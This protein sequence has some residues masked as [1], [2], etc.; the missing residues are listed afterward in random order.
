LREL[1]SIS[2]ALETLLPRMIPAA[3]EEID[4]CEARGRVAFED[5]RAHM[6]IPPFARSPYDGYAFAA[7]DVEGA[8]KYSPVTLRVVREI[9]AGSPA[10]EG[11]GPGE[12]VKLMT[13]APV[14]T[15][16]DTVV[17][18]ETTEFT[19]EAVS[20]FEP[21]SPG[22]DVIPAGED[23]LA[24]DVII[25]KGELI[26]AAVSGML[27]AQGLSRVKV[28]VRPVA[29]ILSTGSELAGRTELIGDGKIHD[30]NRYSLGAA[31]AGLGLSVRFIG[32]RAD[33]PEGIAEAVKKGLEDCD[34][35]LTTGGVSVGDYDYTAS[36]SEAAGVG[37]L[38][39]NVN[40]KPGGTCAIGMKGEKPVFCLSGNPASSLIAFYVLAQP[41]LKKLCGHRD[42]RNPAIQVKL[43]HGIKKASPKPRLVRGALDLS[44]GTARLVPHE[45]QGNGVLRS[46][47]GCNLI[48]LIP[49]GSPPQKAGAEIT[50]WLVD[51]L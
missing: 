40:M 21:S 10:G 2:A 26:D 29:G 37:M 45:G 17:K 42:P 47:K 46:M 1:I 41:C 13:G 39:R 16:A 8:G 25:A 32:T 27:A 51:S 36:A 20:I 43:A 5:V 11:I 12:A 4:L 3:G 44:D 14:P 22:R 30:S 24:G 35:L 15:G 18:F 6:S 31:C 34:L 28:Y 19:E 48:G 50:A 38:V 7:R 33:S 23:V 9:A 49:E